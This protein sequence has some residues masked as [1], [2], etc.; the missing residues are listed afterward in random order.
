MD[1][2]TAN[3]ECTLS[4]VCVVVTESNLNASARR[5]NVSIYY[6]VNLFSI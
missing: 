2:L 1:P 3:V 5:H 6:G 4:I